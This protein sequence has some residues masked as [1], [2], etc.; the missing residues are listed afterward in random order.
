VFSQFPLGTFLNKSYPRNHLYRTGQSLIEVEVTGEFG[1]D[2]SY[3]PAA[4]VASIRAAFS[5]YASPMRE[6]LGMLHKRGPHEIALANSAILLHLLHRLID[7]KVLPRE[8]ALAL[9]DD[10][11][12]W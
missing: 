5:C 9:L 11:A 3:L 10:A 7:G 4:E 2:L 6:G 1:R 12:D 8:Q